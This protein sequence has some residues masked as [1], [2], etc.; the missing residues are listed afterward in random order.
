MPCMAAKNEPLS[1]LRRCESRSGT[2]RGVTM[3]YYCQAQ[4]PHLI[5]S[6]RDSVGGLDIVEDPRLVPLRYQFPAQDLEVAQAKCVKMRKKS[7]ASDRYSRGP[8]RGT[9]SQ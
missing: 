6:V 1:H 2:L 7:L 9:C 4:D 3:S 5:R 8:L